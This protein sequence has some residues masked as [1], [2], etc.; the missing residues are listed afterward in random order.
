MEKFLKDLFAALAEGRCPELRRLVRAVVT[1]TESTPLERIRQALLRQRV[2]I[3]AILDAGGS[4][5]GILT[6]EDLL[7]EVVGEIQDEQDVG[8]VPPIVHLGD[9]HFEVDGRL[10]FDVAE[11]ELGLAIRP[12]PTGI[13]TLGGLVMARLETLPRRGQSVVVEGRRLTVL[14]VRDRRVARLAIEPAE[15]EANADLLAGVDE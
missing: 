7:E 3:A 8:E 13:E 9:R 4:F 11:R 15:P 12:A 1:A 6:L 14:Q 2:H 10:T 5:I